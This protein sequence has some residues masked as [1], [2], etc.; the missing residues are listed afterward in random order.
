MKER[1]SKE[2]LRRILVEFKGEGIPDDLKDRRAEVDPVKGKANTIAGVRRSGKTYLMY[3]LMRGC[4]EGRAYYVNYEDERLINPN[5]EDLTNLL[6][7]IRE[8]FEVEKPIFLFVDE[9]Q[10]AENWEQWTRRL[11]SF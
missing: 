11:I 1:D 10:N 5:V 6:P 4:G 7:T 8:T 2:I 9:I 3:Q